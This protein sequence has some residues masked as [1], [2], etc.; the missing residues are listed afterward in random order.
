MASSS[1]KARDYV[2]ESLSNENDEPLLFHHNYP[3]KD[4]HHRCEFPIQALNVVTFDLNCHTAH[5]IVS[6]LVCLMRQGCARSKAMSRWN[7]FSPFVGSSKEEIPLLTVIHQVTL[8]RAIKA[9]LVHSINKIAPIC[10]EFL[11]CYRACQ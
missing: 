6:P 4:S 8:V 11:P 1:A 3:W 2:M 7:I 10:G 9:C 5:Q